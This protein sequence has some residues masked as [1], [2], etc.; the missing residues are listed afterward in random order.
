[1]TRPAGHRRP[2]EIRTLDDRT[3]IKESNL[4]KVQLVRR[5]EEIRAKL[6]PRPLAESKLL[7]QAEVDIEIFR[8]ANEFLPM[9]G[10]PEAAIRKYFCPPPGNCLQAG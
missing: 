3:V 1:M 9:P 10:G 5:I 8:T 7:H 2:A 4:L 6:D